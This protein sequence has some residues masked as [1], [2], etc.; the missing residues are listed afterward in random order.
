MVA[1]NDLDLRSVPSI[2]RR[3]AS[4]DYDIVHLHTKRAHALTLW[5]DRNRPRPKYLVTRRMD[6]PEARNWY[7]RCLYNR[8][9]DGVVAISQYIL[10]GLVH[11]GVERGKIRLIHSGIDANRFTLSAAVVKDASA[12][13]NI[14]CLAVL[15]QRKGIEYMLD[16]AGVL[17]RRGLRLHWLIGGA[18]RRR[19]ALENKVTE[20]GLGD[21]VRFLGFVANP[22]EFFRSIDVFVM[23]SL[24]EGLGVAALEAMAAAKPV[25][26]TRVG[27][28]MESVLDGQSGF[29][30]APGD[31]DAIANAIAELVADPPMARQ[32]GLLGRRRVLEKFT[33]NQMAAQ[34]EAYYYELLGV[35][36]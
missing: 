25:V 2:R 34:N 7:T 3:I 23:P 33:L 36:N 28:L 29:L 12:A 30:V 16:A 10:E 11:A 6:Y 26:A 15:E 17:Q 21:S 20:L 22:E 24:F 4:G 13:V 31:G 8:R 5:L 14:G 18:G 35:E 1:R 19:E 32:M 27:G 9:V